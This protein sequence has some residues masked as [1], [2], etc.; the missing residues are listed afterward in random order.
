MKLKKYD[1]MICDE[2]NCNPMVEKHNGDYCLVDD[3]IDEVR[4]RIN[5]SNT[6]PEQQ[7]AYQHMLEWIGAK[8]Y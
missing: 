8:E 2:D 3:I 5:V 7:I 1:V 6:L 4:T